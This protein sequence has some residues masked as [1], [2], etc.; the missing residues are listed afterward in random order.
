[1]D[2]QAVDRH[3]LCGKCNTRLPLP[4][5]AAPGKPLTVTDSTFNRAVLEAGS[6]PVLLDAGRP[7]AAR[8]G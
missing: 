6:T 7:G 1:M 3:P 8:A 4:G 2:D 5:Q